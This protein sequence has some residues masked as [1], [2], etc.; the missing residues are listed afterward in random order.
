M[1]LGR[2]GRVQKDR[3]RVQIV[4]GCLSPF[5]KNPIVSLIFLIKEQEVFMK[6]YF[7]IL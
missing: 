5:L 4:V 7:H 6:S 1:K 3:H 2:M